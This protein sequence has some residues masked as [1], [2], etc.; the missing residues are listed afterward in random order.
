MVCLALVKSERCTHK[1]KLENRKNPLKIR[2]VIS[3]TEMT[4][5]CFGPTIGYNLFWYYLFRFLKGFTPK[6][7]IFC[8]YP[9]TINHLKFTWNLNTVVTFF[10]L[11]TKRTIL[12]PLFKGF[13]FILTQGIIF[14]QETACIWSIFIKGQE[15]G[16][17]MSNRVKL[18]A[19]SQKIYEYTV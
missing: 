7:L 19:G 6:M 5:T 8:N 4:T 9:L 12:K 10:N 11:P 14:L 17:K 13:Y 15:M 3:D 16:L 18:V 2:L 1:I